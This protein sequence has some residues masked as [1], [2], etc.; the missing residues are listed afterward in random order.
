VPLRF[1]GRLDALR[2]TGRRF[3]SC[4]LLRLNLLL[5]IVWQILD[6]LRRAQVV[7]TRR[8]VRPVGAV[9]I[10]PIKQVLVAT[11]LID[12][13]LRHILRRRARSSQLLLDF[14]WY[15]DLLMNQKRAT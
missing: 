15:F 4:W 6:E 1:G 3:L 14:A 8:T 11:Q 12:Q 7:L 10:T 5:S 9:P 2:W 13:Q